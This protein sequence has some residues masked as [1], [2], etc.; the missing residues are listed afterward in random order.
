MALM[1]SKQQTYKLVQQLFK[2]CV[3]YDYLCNR[4]RVNFFML[5]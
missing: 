1:N 4:K 3:E 5:Q 2:N